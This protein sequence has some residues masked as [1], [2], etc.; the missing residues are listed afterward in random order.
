MSVKQDVDAREHFLNTLQWLLAVVTRY[1][2]HFN[3]ALVKI[4]YG[5]ENELGNAYGAVDASKHLTE[6][7]Q[8]LQTIFRKSDLIARNGTDVWVLFP[9][10][11]FSENIYL[12]IREVIDSTDH[13]A[14]HIVN[15]KI[16]IFTSPF[17]DNEKLPTDSAIETLNYL[18]ENQSLM[19]DHTFMLTKKETEQ[20]A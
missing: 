6:V 18:K 8:A 1:S 20:A 14:L 5:D 17:K 10:T 2:D 9:Y 4:A 13:E 7:T 19:A 12:K 15:R 16:A 11:P 3:F